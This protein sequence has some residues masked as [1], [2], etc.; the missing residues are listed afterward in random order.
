[1]RRSA[2]SS[3]FTLME[4]L[5]ALV[6]AGAVITPL[7]IITRGVAEQTGS[8]QM[9]IEAMQRARIGMDTLIRDFS[10]AGLFTSPNTAADSRFL[11]RE[12]SGSNARY[13]PAAAHLNADSSGPDSVM[14]AGNFLGSKMYRAYVTGID[15]MVFTD[16]ISSEEECT[17]QF[18][19]HYAFLHISDGSGRELDAKVVSVDYSSSVCQVTI[20]SADY[21]VRAFK[22]GDTVFVSANQTLVYRVENDS[23]VRYFA[24][25]ESPETPNGGDCDPSASGGAVKIVEG[26]RQVVANFVQDFQVWFRPVSDEAGWSEPHYQTLGDIISENEGNFA[27]GLTPPDTLA[28]IPLEA[29]GS[30]S[31]DSVTCAALQTDGTSLIGPERVRSALIRLTVRSEKSEASMRRLPDDE[32]SRL[33]KRL[34]A[35][36]SNT[37]TAAGEDPYA[38]LLRTV[39][40][41]VEMPNL[42]A[43]WDLL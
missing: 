33:E 7:Y 24:T 9:E 21:D 29:G 17:R 18:S 3:G 10:R 25:Y 8:K 42:A 20:D 41:E 31:S 22:T 40:T 6:M 37:A 34:L 1:M 30:V 2:I 14:L 43:R 32:A 11:N 19:E 15:T 28:V 26:T 38:Y 27:E 4:M 35:A 23:L 39:T 13:R 16:A 12:V 5:V 36:D